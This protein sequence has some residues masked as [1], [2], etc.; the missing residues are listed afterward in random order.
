MKLPDDRDRTCAKSS[1]QNIYRYRPNLTI[2]PSAGM[3]DSLGSSPFVT[4]T[5]TVAST[6]AVGTTVTSTSAVGT[7]A[8]SGSV[9]AARFAADVESVEQLQRKYEL[10]RLRSQVAQLQRDNAEVAEQL[11]MEREARKAEVDVFL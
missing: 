9:M 8:P 3:A 1:G 11:R 2:Q 7:T 10:I 5:P 4:E 6:S